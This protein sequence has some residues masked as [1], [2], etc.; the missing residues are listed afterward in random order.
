MIN[1]LI[2][3][4]RLQFRYAT[5]YIG[6][7]ITSVIAIS[8]ILLSLYLQQS[9]TVRDVTAIVTCGLV[10]TTLIYHAKNLRV[11]VELTREK[12]D[13]DRMKYAEEKAL[14]VQE[15][16][17]NRLLHSFQVSSLWFKPDMANH[18]ELARKFLRQHRDKLEVHVPINLFQQELEN[19]L[20]ARKALICV[21]NYFENIALLIK[22]GL[23]D[24]ECIKL[25]F[26]TLFVDYLKVLS[27]YIDEI[28]KQNSRFL[29]NYEEIGK[30]WS[31]E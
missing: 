28:Q 14:K 17:W 12:I 15:A 31:V 10:C 6:T 7:T 24:E 20:T 13:F 26:R 27:R 18:V 19:D 2:D 11:N 21:L 5:L 8:F 30:K 9:V 16:E 3:T 22:Y 1:T 23:V 29:M 4:T 25:C